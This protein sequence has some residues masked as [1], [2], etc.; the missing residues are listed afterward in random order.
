MGPAFGA[1]VE[2]D[3]VW[4]EL[5]GSAILQFDLSQ[6]TLA[7]Y[8]QMRYH[9]QI[10]VS[11]TALAFMIHQVD[12][13]IECEDKKIQDMVEG[14]MR[15]MWTR[16]IRAMSQS[17]WA[18]YSPTAIEYENNPQT[19]YVE[20]TKFKDLIPEDCFVHWKEVPGSAVPP[21]GGKPPKFKVFDG[22][23]Q[24]GMPTI[25]PANSLWYPLLMENGNYYGR[26]LL[27]AAFAPWYFSIL[28]HLFANRYYERFGEP[29]PI[30]RYPSNEDVEQGDGTTKSAKQVMETILMSLRNRSVVTLP[31][32]K[33]QVGMGQSARYDYDWQLEY[34]ESQM[35]GADFERY[36]ARLD[37]EISLALFTPMLLMRSGDVGSHNLGVQH[38]QTWLWFLNALVGDMKEYIDRY[39]CERLKA[40]NFTPN[41][42]R[43]QWV[44]RKMG[45]ENVETLRT[46]IAALLSGDGTQAVK[47]DLVELGQMMGLKLEEVDQLA[48]PDGKGGPGDNPTD[49]RGREK[50]DRS[51]DGP[52][53]VGEPRA[54]GREISNRI[55]GQVE[56]AWRERTFGKEFKPTLGYRRKFEMAL[57]AEG[58]AADRA[59]SM[60]NEFYHRVESWLQTAVSLGMSEFDGPSDFCSMLER[61]IDSEIE[62]L[63]A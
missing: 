20:I 14:N 7:D 15:E 42:P 19:K 31:S 23:D 22:I 33:T 18:G 13:H 21:K 60:A 54:T 55:R 11:L 5:P 62:A 51:S 58:V 10:N 44:V 36:M 61:K 8:R 57:Q 28:I 16:L 27:K 50:R 34:L 49:D 26:K 59:V 45:K 12:W 24:V 37:E 32:D 25:P 3:I 43:C 46:I 48:I 47:L 38:A 30:G 1:W 6:L 35:R 17:Y 41:A 29:T 52:K 4:A 63:R 9:P 40:I 53:G 2:R 39:I 56:K